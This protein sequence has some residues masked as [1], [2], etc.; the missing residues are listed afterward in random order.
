MRA[1]AEAQIYLKDIGEAL[2]TR[3]F[4]VE[5]ATPYGEPVAEWIIQ[6]VGLRHAEMIVM[7]THG[8]TGP[9]RWMFGSVAPLVLVRPSTANAATAP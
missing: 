1:L 5:R 2:G 4:V 6:E 8:R 3:G 7:T 9:G